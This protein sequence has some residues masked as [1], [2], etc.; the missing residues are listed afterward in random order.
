MFW[1]DLDSPGV[2]IRPTRCESGRDEVAE[3]FFDDVPVPGDRLV[4]AVGGG[5]AAV[6]YLMQF[7]RGAYA[8][9][10]QAELHSQ[11]QELIAEAPAAAL[12]QHTDVIGDAYLAL[13]ALRS[14]AV[15][16]LVTLTSGTDLGPEI[17]VDKLL[18]SSAEQTTT[19]AARTVLWPAVELDDS[20]VAARWRRRW[21]FARIT[22][23]YGG[24]A[25]VQ[26]D[27]VSERLLGLPRGR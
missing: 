17:S 6:M 10:R 16:T 23:I 8:W 9:K 12:A 3:L 2:T 25:E 19:D 22:T 13:F 15:A 4:G 14:Q 26:R 1:I 24:A 18:L 27:I 20:P 21:S 5:W 7:E 11:L